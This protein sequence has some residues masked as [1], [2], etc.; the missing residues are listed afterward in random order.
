[1]PV[2]T[3]APGV[4]STITPTGQGANS[5]TVAITYNARGLRDTLTITPTGQ[6]QPA[7][8]EHFVYRGSQVG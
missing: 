5:S 2:S 6:G 3:R 8:R 7:F 4:T 1:V